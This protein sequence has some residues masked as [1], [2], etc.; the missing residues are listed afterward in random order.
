MAARI[1]NL[2]RKEM[3]HFARDRMLTTFLFLLPIIQLALLARATG[4]DIGNLRV[5]VLDLDRSELTREL[6]SSMENRDELV[7][8]YFV[9]DEQELREM[10]DWGRA[11]VGVVFPS[12]LSQDLANPAVAGQVKVVVNGAN[13]L[14]GSAGIRT[15]SAVFT[16][17][18]QDLLREQGIEVDPVIDLRVVTYYNPSYNIRFFAIPAQVG[19]ITYQITLAFASLGLARERELGTLEQLIVT[20]L[21]RLELLLG[22]AIPALLIGLLNFVLLLAVAVFWFGVPLEGSFPLLFGMTVLFLLAEIGW[23]MLISSVARTQQQSILFVFI[24]AMV[25]MTF[26]GYLVPIQN[27]PGTL[28]MISKASPM[29]HYLVVIRAVMLKGATLSTLW[30][31]GLVLGL[32]GVLIPS[33]AIGR[34]SRGLD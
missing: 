22:K 7:I 34:V 19:F 25:D 15:A 12:G 23:G 17:Y 10:L 5:A 11:E 32:L 3:I 27:L 16:D 18:G 20:P 33:M 14:V 28:Q 2:I 30:P 29:Y 21:G 6:I 1:W 24:L 8:S 13:S 26:S 4:K 9:D 31:N